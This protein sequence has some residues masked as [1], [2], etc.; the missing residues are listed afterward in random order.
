MTVYCDMT[1]F[2]GGWTQI[3][4]Q[5]VDVLLGYLPTT[6]WANGVR[7]DLPDSGQYS[8][9]HLIDE[10]ES[11]SGDFEFLIDWPND[12]TD[13]VRWKQTGDPRV[14]PGTVSELDPSPTNQKGCVGDDFAGL[15]AEGDGSSTWDGDP[16]TIGTTSCWWWAIGTSAAFGTGIPAYKSSDANG[17]LVASR[18]RL[19]VR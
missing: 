2:E 8:I 3:Y 6:A 4:D 19:W 15:A 14:A 12:G 1:R 10:F 18:T 7:T 5:D 17:Q 13:Y 16:G 11:L 9:L